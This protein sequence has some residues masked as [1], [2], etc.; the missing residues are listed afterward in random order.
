MLQSPHIEDM[1][2]R[3][4]IDEPPPL[5]RIPM[6]PAPL[7]KVDP[8]MRKSN[9][10]KGEHKWPFDPTSR[11]G[12]A[13]ILKRGLLLDDF[14]VICGT[15]LIKALSGDSNRTKDTF[16]LQQYHK[17][18]CCLHVPHSFHSQDSAGHAVETL[19]C[20]SAGKCSSFYA[21]STVS[22]GR[23]RILVTSEVDAR[24]S[25][26]DVLELKS[27]SK[28]KGMEFVDGGVALQIA[29]NGSQHLL[30]CSLDVSQTHLIQTESISAAAVV[31][32]H[33]TAFINQGQRVMLLLERVLSHACFERVAPSP[34]VGCVL[35]MTFDDTKA[36]VIAPAPVGIG[37]LPDGI[38][39]EGSTS[40]DSRL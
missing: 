9:I 22:I 24:D 11:L 26:D 15:S 28:K 2:V 6:L 34:E 23:Y 33:S 27:S 29:L 17:T 1:L 25:S 19:L 4:Y 38:V 40:V 30:G 31:Q 37:V 3:C 20:G 36:P 35:K 7:P 5:V 21:C 18:L 13:V 14:D 16:Y 32:A 12:I 8:K 10:A 39:N